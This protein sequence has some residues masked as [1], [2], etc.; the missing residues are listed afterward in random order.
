M[1]SPL[2]SRELA[3]DFVLLNAHAAAR[4]N[5]GRDLPLLRLGQAWWLFATSGTGD[6]WAVSL[7]A[8]QDVGGCIAP[9][10]I[11]F[12]DHDAGPDAQVQVLPIDF[13]QWLQLALLMAD[14][15]A[16]EPSAAEVRQRLNA[17]TPGLADVYPYELS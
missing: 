5:A 13:G 6:A 2:P 15:E 11:G 12:V 7:H 14:C 4:E 10:R 8:P 17:L 9:E 16:Q 3:G 1:T